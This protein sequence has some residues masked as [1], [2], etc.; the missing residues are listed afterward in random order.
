MHECQMNTDRRAQTKTGCDTQDK[1]NR[2][3]L[4]ALYRN[5]LQL[6]QNAAVLHFVYSLLRKLHFIFLLKWFL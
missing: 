6:R 5:L 4:L 1:D 3:R 2:N